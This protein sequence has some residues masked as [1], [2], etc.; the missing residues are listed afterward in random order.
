MSYVFVVECKGNIIFKDKHYIAIYV[1]I[2]TYIYIFANFFYFYGCK[3]VKF[4]LQL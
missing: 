3:T 4:N 2:Y 1:Y